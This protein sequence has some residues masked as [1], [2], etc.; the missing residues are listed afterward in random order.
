MSLDGTYSGLIASVNDWLKRADLTTVAADFIALAESQM[1]LE[2]R[3]RD[4]WFVKTVT[5]TQETLRLPC[6]LLSIESFRL[7]QT[8]DGLW[9][10]GKLSYRTPQQMDELPVGVFGCPRH[11]TIAGGSFVFWPIPVPPVAPAQPFMARLRGIERIPSL[12]ASNP[13]N[14]LLSKYPHAYLYGALLQSA[15][16]LKADDRIQV[17]SGLF[18]DAITK[19][20]ASDRGLIAD[21]LQTQSGVN[22]GVRRRHFAGQV[23]P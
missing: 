4:M 9:D 14:W 8:G 11:Y 5:L 20:N 15:P 16:Y 19:I 23:N 21:S 7:N 13:S 12:L 17:W 10:G 22:D 6:D 1:N 18:S 2:L 3:C